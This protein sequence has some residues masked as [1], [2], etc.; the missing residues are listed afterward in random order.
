M[1]EVAGCDVWSVGMTEP[2]NM[3]LFGS[4]VLVVTVPEVWAVVVAA[5][6]EVWVVAK[7]GTGVGLVTEALVTEPRVVVAT[8]A[9]V[10]V[11]AV[12]Q[13]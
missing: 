5:D 10:Q 4:W 7:I 6:P 3:R 11:V 2:R 8:G 12:I 9:Q 1:E 13:S